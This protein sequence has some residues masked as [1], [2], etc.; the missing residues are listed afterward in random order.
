MGIS[1]QET[2]KNRKEMRQDIPETKFSNEDIGQTRSGRHR[3]HTG[4]I[5]QDKAGQRD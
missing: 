5:R 3:K 1:A 2:G 4:H